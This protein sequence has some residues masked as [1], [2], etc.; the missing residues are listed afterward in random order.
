MKNNWLSAADNCRSLDQM[1]K[2]CSEIISSIHA[3]GEQQSAARKAL[4]A[5]EQAL[6]PRSTPTAS[7]YAQHRFASLKLTL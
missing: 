3:N 6:R 2:L 7:S 4:N 1:K 5:I